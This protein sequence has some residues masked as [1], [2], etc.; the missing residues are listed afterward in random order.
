M[1]KKLTLALILAVAASGF[2][3]AGSRP[4]GARKDS[5]R[6]VAAR[7][8][9]SW[10]RGPVL[11]RA[12]GF[13]L[14]VGIELPAGLS[15][16]PDPVGADGGKVGVLPAPLLPERP[17]GPP[18]SGLGPNLQWIFQAPVLFEEP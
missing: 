16:G 6:T 13:L 2:S 3:A 18:E 9:S 1:R 5:D 15:D 8:M 10:L 12:A 14:P 11:R 7:E 17:E 4:V